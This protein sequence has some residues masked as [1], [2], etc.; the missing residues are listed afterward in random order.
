[1]STDLV[2]AIAFAMQAHMGQVDKAGAPYILHPLR[3]MAAQ[4]SAA[5]RIVAVLH[6]VFEDSDMKPSDMIFDDGERLG[7]YTG[8]DILCALESLTR[9]PGEKY[10]AYLERV[11]ANPIGRK[12]KIADLF[13]N[14]RLDRFSQPTQKDQER[15]AKYLAHAKALLAAEPRSAATVSDELS[16][17]SVEIAALEDRKRKLYKESLD[18][19]ENF[20]VCED[21]FAEMAGTTPPPVEP[22]LV[23]YLTWDDKA[24]VFRASKKMFLVKVRLAD[25]SKTHLGVMLGDIA[26]SASATY[27]REDQ[28]LRIGPSMLNPAIFVPALG[29]LVFGMESWWGRIDSEEDMKDITDETINSSAPVR[30]LV[31][32]LGRAKDG[33]ASALGVEPA[34]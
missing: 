21:W 7:E 28:V 23:A 5:T 1:M 2:N 27:N 16:R 19:P 13:D 9:R 24:Q 25:D 32:L 10:D 8:E 3:V 30:L 11:A 22:R 34:K 26:L 29:R 31:E 17:I 20:K 12:V 33:A 15:C 6:D 18:A 4:N 14:A